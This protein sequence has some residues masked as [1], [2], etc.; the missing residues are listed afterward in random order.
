MQ[1]FAGRLF[2]GAV[3]KPANMLGVELEDVRLNGE[4]ELAFATRD[5]D[6]GMGTIKQGTISG[7]SYEYAGIVDGKPFVTHSGYIS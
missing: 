1:N 6:L 4:I 5:L 2:P 3:P 7:A